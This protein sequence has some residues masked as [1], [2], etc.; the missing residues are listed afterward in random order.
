MR[1]KC[2]EAVKLKSFKDIGVSELVCSIM[3]GNCIDEIILA[4]RTGNLEDVLKEVV[5]PNNMAVC[6]LG[7]QSA[8]KKAGYLRDDFVKYQVSFNW[9]ALMRAA[10]NGRYDESYFDEASNICRELRYFSNEEYEKF[11]GF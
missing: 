2:K 4:A 6:Y 7:V 8:L 1:R 9:M 11:E 5:D 3:D 10:V